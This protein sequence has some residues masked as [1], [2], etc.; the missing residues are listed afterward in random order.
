MFLSNSLFQWEQF[1]L[2]RE[3]RRVCGG[4]QAGRRRAGRQQVMCLPPEC[5]HMLCPWI[6][7]RATVNP[8]PPL[9][10]G[11]RAFTVPYTAGQLVGPAQP[12]S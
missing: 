7:G 10:R 8:E 5:L 12:T 9:A 1:A 11:Q 3:Q 6:Y 4:G 2:N